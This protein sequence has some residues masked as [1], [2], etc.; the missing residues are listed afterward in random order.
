M[1][2]YGLRVGPTLRAQPQ[3]RRQRRLHPCSLF[4]KRDPV[5]FMRRVARNQRRLDIGYQQRQIACS[6][7]FR[8]ARANQFAKQ[9]S[10]IVVQRCRRA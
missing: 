4:P 1:A 7:V 5:R 6:K 9:R 3:A 10:L 8:S 2:S